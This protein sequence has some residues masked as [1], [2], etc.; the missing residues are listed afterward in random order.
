[1]TIENKVIGTD[2]TIRAGHLRELGFN[3]MHY[4]DGLIWYHPKLKPKYM[5]NKNYYKRN[6]YV[7]LTLKMW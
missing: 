6:D 3:Y 2:I 1:M 4:G 5:S 7:N